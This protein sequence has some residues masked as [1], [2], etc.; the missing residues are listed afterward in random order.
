M[1]VEGINCASELIKANY[2]IEKVII[3]KESGEKFTDLIDSCTK[4]KIKYEIVDKK[5]LEKI[6]KSGHSQG[7]VCFVR[8][9]EYCYVED[10]LEVSKEK[11]TAPFIMILDSIVDPHN[12]GAIIRTA[13]CMGVDGIIIGQNRACEVNETVFKT[14]TGAVAHVKI[15]QVVNISQTLEKLKKENIWCYALE[16]GEDRISDIDFTGGI[17]LVV[18][19]EGK[20]VS[21]L[22]KKTCDGTVSIPMYGKINSLNASNASAIA[23]YEVARQRLK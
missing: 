20:G 2:P 15:A 5:G 18:G 22:V 3:N 17:A 23:M 13:E 10:I 11:G 14:S 19:S 4:N 21:R 7:V 8:P 1:I 16:A 6:T 9:Y 12:V